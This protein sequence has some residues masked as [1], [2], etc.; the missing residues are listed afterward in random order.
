MILIEFIFLHFYGNIWLRIAEILMG[1][2]SIANIFLYT[3]RLLQMRI[4]KGLIV[5]ALLY[6]V[7][8]VL[9]TLHN[10]DDNPLS[11]MMPLIAI[12]WWWA[13]YKG[14]QKDEKLVRSLDRIR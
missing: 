2:V 8:R 1:V 5:A 9:Y 7:C 3:N 12:V 10:H 6:M 11:V 13:A 4:C 14:I